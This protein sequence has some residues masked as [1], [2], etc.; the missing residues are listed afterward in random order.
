MENGPNLSPG[1]TPPAATATEDPTLSPGAPAS[2][3]IVVAGG[4]D[5]SRERMRDWLLHEFPASGVFEAASADDLRRL[6][7]A[8]AVIFVDI[9]L[10]A[11]HGVNLL[12]LARTLAP[13][14]APV[15]LSTYHAD[16]YWNYAIG[17]GAV[18]CVSPQVLDG[19]LKT[20]V[21]LLLRAARPGSA[22]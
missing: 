20:L 5:R 12:R 18:A 21:E 3:V 8:A 13:D 4:T 17:A 22:T 11:M 1:S 9:D 19:S 16:S 7:P 10:P 14:A 6:A 15:A 2:S